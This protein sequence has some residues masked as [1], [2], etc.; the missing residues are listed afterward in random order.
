LYCDAVSSSLRT[1]DLVYRRPP[2]GLSR[3]TKK[4]RKEIKA[5]KEKK[6]SANDRARV[7]KTENHVK[8]KSQMGT[9]PPTTLLNR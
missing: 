1:G 5:R 7:K 3:E 2:Q 8:E 4:V 6:E 9:N